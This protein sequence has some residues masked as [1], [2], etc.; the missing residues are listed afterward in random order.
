[1]RSKAP[2]VVG[3][4]VVAAVLRIAVV[5]AAQ[6]KVSLDKDPNLVGWWKFDETTGATAIDEIEAISQGKSDKPLA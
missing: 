3:F 6:E 2:H 4:F 5:T 1:M